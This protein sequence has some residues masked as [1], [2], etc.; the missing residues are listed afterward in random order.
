MSLIYSI[1]QQVK[2]SDLN[3]DLTNRNRKNVFFG[4]EA[5]KHPSTPKVFTPLTSREDQVFVFS[6]GFQPINQVGIRRRLVAALFSVVYH[7]ERMMGVCVL[8]FFDREPRREPTAVSWNALQALHTRVLPPVIHSKVIGL[9]FEKC[10]VHSTPRPGSTER[11]LNESLF[12]GQFEGVRCLDAACT[13]LFL[14][15]RPV[16]SFRL[17]LLPQREEQEDQN[18][19][20]YEDQYYHDRHNDL[21]DLQFLEK[22]QHISH[23][24]PIRSFSSSHA[25]TFLCFTTLSRMCVISR[26]YDTLCDISKQLVRCTQTA[27]IS[28]ANSL[29]VTVIFH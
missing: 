17:P 21:H 13:R 10:P 29:L 16:R 28:K 22:K 9:V 8:L 19:Y 3:Q 7:K 14:R 27:S 12:F 26:R 1:Q 15:A 20:Q 23:F 11:A 5:D 4:K 25:Q 2:A 24:L 18:S 6:S